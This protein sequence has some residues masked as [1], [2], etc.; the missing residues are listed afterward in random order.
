MKNIDYE[1]IA[2]GFLTVPQVAMMLGVT[3][4]T[5]YNWMARGRIAYFQVGSR[6]RIPE[7]SLE[8]IISEFKKKPSR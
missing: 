5:V 7:S 4:A 2:S 1:K 3:R 6:R 8:A